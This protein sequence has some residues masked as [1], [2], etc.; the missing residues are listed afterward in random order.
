[1]KNL[2]NIKVEGSEGDGLSVELLNLNGTVLFTDKYDFKGDV[3]KH[4]LDL[5]Y[6]SDGIYLIR[7]TD[8][9]NQKTLKIIKK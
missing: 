7:V 9:V 3:Y 5:S 4:Q 6:I 2:L 1:M 8:G